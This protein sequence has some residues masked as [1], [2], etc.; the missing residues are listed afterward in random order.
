MVFAGTNFYHQLLRKYV[1]VFGS[2][3]NTIS[4][5]RTDANNNVTF[6]MKVPLQFASKE[7]MVVRL[8]QDPGADRPFA[9]AMPM[10]TFDFRHPGIVYAADRQQNPI[11]RHVVRNPDDKNKFKTVFVPVPY[12]IHFSLYVY[13]KNAEDGAKIVEQILPFFT[14]AWTVTM[15]LI[16]EIDEIRDIPVILRNVTMDDVNDRDFTARRVLIWT[17]DFVMK[18]YFYG[19]RRDKAM[20]KVVNLNEWID[21][22]NGAAYHAPDTDTSLSTNV[23]I[24][25]STDPVETVTAQPG[26][27]ANGYPTTSVNNSISWTVIDVNDDYGFASMIEDTSG[28]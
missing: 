19:P 20:I 14:P 1:V 5:Q 24:L 22:S 26:L 3:F 2:F 21:Q 10:M 12:D 28:R 18:G 16:P 7:K 15:E 25:S 6:D 17:L 13:V 11:I 4:I 27:L 8:F 23:D 9:A